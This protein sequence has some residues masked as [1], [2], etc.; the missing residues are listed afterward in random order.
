MLIVSLQMCA[1]VLCCG[2]GCF[3]RINLD[4]ASNR[5]RHS[6]CIEMKIYEWRAVLPEPT[7]PAYIYTSCSYGLFTGSEIERECEYDVAKK[8][9][10]MMLFTQPTGNVWRKIDILFKFLARTSL[11]FM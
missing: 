7:G 11:G 4:K 3:I 6:Y 5:N 1:D 9:V 10:S 2:N 8:S